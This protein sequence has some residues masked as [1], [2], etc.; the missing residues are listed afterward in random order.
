[1]GKPR[2]TIVQTELGQAHKDFIQ[3][4]EPDFVLVKIHYARQFLKRGIT[5]DDRFPSDT[6]VITTTSIRDDK[7]SALPGEHNGYRRGEWDIVREFEPDYHIPSDE[8]DYLDFPDEKRYN[9]VQDC[10]EG[11]VNMANHI[12][13]ADIATRILPWFK[14][15]TKKER[16]TTYR[17]VE[18]LGLDYMVFYAN[19]YFNGRDGNYRRE[20]VEDLELIV[21]E[22]T[23]VMN[24]IDDI[25][26]CVLNCQS[27]NLLSKFPDEVV[28]SSGLWVGQ[29]RGWREKIVPTKQ[30]DTEMREIFDDVDE[31]VCEALGVQPDRQSVTSDQRVETPAGNVT[32][33][34]ES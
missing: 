19:G 12:A 17:T 9:R 29:N 14:G 32:G 3:A 1:M 2:G 16:L 6:Q 22:A 31:R 34:T 24:H 8:S 33:E 21:D 13:D 7:N 4:V 15:V 20:L 27:P 26:I 11:T 23:T 5:A 10:M 30:T 18:Q 25:E 28:A